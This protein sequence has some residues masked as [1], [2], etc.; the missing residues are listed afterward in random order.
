LATPTGF[1]ATL[2]AS[3]TTVALRWLDGSNNETGFVVESSLNGGAFTQIGTVTSTARN[4]TRTGTALT[5]NAPVVGGSYVF[6]VKAVNATGNSLYATSAAIVVIAP[7][8]PTAPTAVTATS[9]N[10]G[11]TR[12]T[13][14]V[15]W[16][17]ASTT[18][19]GFTV[20]RCN[21][22]CTAAT[23]AASW[24]QVGTGTSAVG[25]GTA[26]S[27]SDTRRAANTTY[28][29]RVIATGNGGLNSTPVIVTVTTQP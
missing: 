25:T 24:T 28:S 8:A 26:R 10:A 15:S 4:V 11:G 23:P 27:F 12:R 3:N 17:D 19:T 22:V 18:E 2:Q 9:A 14:T 29:Y 5:F 16:T 13:V 1:T 21:G 7:V 20:Q 6:R